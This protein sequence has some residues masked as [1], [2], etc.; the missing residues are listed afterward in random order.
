MTVLK[1][2]RRIHIRRRSPEPEAHAFPAE[3]AARRT[4]TPTRVEPDLV[5]ALIASGRRKESDP[6][7]DEPKRITL[8]GVVVVE[9][10]EPIPVFDLPDADPD[11]LA[12]AIAAAEEEKVQRK[13]A[14][15]EKLRS[16]FLGE[17]K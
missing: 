13:L 14:E 11:V 9:D 8:L 4:Q 12:Q 3:A 15:S 16:Q 2:K 10:G 17:R 6:M 1:P 7:A 5:A